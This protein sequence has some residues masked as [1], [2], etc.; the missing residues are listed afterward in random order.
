MLLQSLSHQIE[1][2]TTYFEGSTVGGNAWKIKLIAKCE[3]IFIGRK[4]QK[5]FVLD[6]KPTGIERYF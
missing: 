1:L 6:A 5:I 2:A 3:H 4:E